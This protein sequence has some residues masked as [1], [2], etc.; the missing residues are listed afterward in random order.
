MLTAYPP[1]ENFHTPTARESVT[2]TLYS[3][4]QQWRL[5]LRRVVDV[6]EPDKFVNV[7]LVDDSP[8]V[9]SF[10][11]LCEEMGYSCW[12]QPGG[13]SSND[14][15]WSLHLNATLKKYVPLVAV[16]RQQGALSPGDDQV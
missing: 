8:T 5:L 6:K 3:D 14:Q 12:W 2:S 1:P 7:K 9:L 11:R 4:I 15:R 16:T 13:S 10:G